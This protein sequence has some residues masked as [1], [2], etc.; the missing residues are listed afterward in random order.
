MNITITAAAVAQ[1]GSGLGKNKYCAPVYFIPNE[2]K[3]F[4]SDF[5]LWRW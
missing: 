2:E 3:E 4:E 5:I 1:C